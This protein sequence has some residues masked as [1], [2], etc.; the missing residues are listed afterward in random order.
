MMQC[1][2]EY[3]KFV[4]ITGYRNIA[5]AKA[6][7]FL[8]FNRKRNIP[9][10][11]IQFFDA[12]LIASPQHLYFAIINA[13]QAFQN[14]TNI[15]KSPAMETILYASAQRQ[16]QKAIQRIG[17]KPETVNIAVTVISKSPT[18]L[19]TAILSITNCFSSEPDDKVLE[20]SKNK[21]KRIIETFQIT[22]KELKTTMKN[23][24]FQETIVNLIIE[25]AALLATQI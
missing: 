2:K 4:E 15:S 1:L 21:T 25:R 16:I 7:E 12:D 6:E 24:N 18:K 11:E 23:N 17:I 9:D 8:K 13:L 22:D 14:K 19:N 5:F 3:S 20:M 10:I